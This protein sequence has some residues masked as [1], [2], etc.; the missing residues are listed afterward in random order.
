MRQPT[1]AATIAKIWT[2]TVTFRPSFG[3]G[4]QR[5]LRATAAQSGER[6]NDQTCNRPRAVFLHVCVGHWHRDRCRKL[7]HLGVAD[8]IQITAA[9]I[10]AARALLDLSTRELSERSGVSRSTIHRA[11]HAQ[12][13][14]NIH[15]ISLTA[16]RATL[17]ELGIEFLEHSGVRLVG[18][19]GTWVNPQ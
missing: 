12:G 14:P 8:E 17:E 6:T 2:A 18:L 1:N 11:E 16:I 4:L 7:A 10:R 15:E 13:I 3:G 5:G 19:D 9:Q